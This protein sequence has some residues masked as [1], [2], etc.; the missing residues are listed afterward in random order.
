VNELPQR[1]FTLNQILQEIENIYK[2]EELVPIGG[3]LGE[4]CCVQMIPKEH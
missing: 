4:A 3:G 1:D 2:F